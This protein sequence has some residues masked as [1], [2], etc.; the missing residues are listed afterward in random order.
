MTAT[1]P[2]G[3]PFTTMP[4]D[5]R[6]TP[7]PPG[8][9]GTPG[10]GIERLLVV[11][12]GSAYAWSTPYWLDLLRLHHPRLDVKVVLTRSAERFVTRQSV[13]S[14]VGG[15]VYGDGWPADAPGARHV[16]WAEWADAFVVYPA[17]LHFLARLALG[18]SDSPALLAAHCSG[19]PVAVAPALPPGGLESPVVRE[20]WATLAARPNVVL[21]PPIPG[22]SLTTGRD[23]AWVPPPLPD[24]LHLLAERLASGNDADKGA[25][26]GAAAGAASPPG[27]TE[28]PDEAYPVREFG[29]GLLHT[30]VDTR[31]LPSG[32]RLW[33]RTPGPL[34]PAPFEQPAQDVTRLLERAAAGP[35]HSGG[36]GPSAG[37]LVPGAEDGPG[38]VYDVCGV[39][40]L[41]HRLLNEGPRPAFAAPLRELGHL[42]RAVHDIPPPAPVQP[43][44]S[45]ALRRL[46]DWLAGRSPVP[47][48]ACA[49]GQVRRALG[50]ERWS[51][52]RTWRDEVAADP[53][54]VLS[55]GAAGLGSLV[56]DRDGIGGGDEP[57]TG[58]DLII[59]EDLCTAPWYV[60]IG[61]IVGEL[62]ELQ[63]QV[64]GDKQAWQ[65]LTDALLEG[66][67]RDLGPEWNR[68]AALR[69]LLH[70][71]DIAAYLEG[72]E[73][74]FD[75]YSGFLRF[76]VD[77]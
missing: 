64:G 66:Y 17:T 42:L 23:D 50:E 68:V 3:P 69:I 32:G 13:A 67:G 7:L 1:A 38:R 60:D 25:A 14:R 21:V 19:A 30:A 33:R 39:T 10:L 8:A 49:L 31:P 11:V 34:A 16:E 74:G 47:R 63:W 22:R 12:T 56:V 70:V 27:P 2:T 29:T 35:G 26:N 43:R 5:P 53:V 72:F 77:L 48:A 61:W 45:R 44:P 20:H 71:H 28:E 73:H 40:S 18:L 24:V 46:D 36:T 76:L 9:P 58:Q 62:V 51:H 59:G 6:G 37:R 57:I 52:L 41:A 75:H 54:T 15:E 55:H 65:R 4:P